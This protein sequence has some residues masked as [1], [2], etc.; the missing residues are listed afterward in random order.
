ME[1]FVGVGTCYLDTILRV[2]YFVE[3]G[4]KAEAA[5]IIR[6]RGGKCPNAIEVLQQLMVAEAA[7]LQVKL[8]AVLP[9]QF[10]P[11]SVDFEVSFAGEDVLRHCIYR[12]D[13][14]EPARRYI[15]RNLQGSSNTIIDHN[16]QGDM[17]LAEFKKAAKKLDTEAAW[18]HFEGR[19]PDVTLKC[20]KHL[21]LKYP[22][23]KISV[24]LD[25][26]ARPGMPDLAPHADVVFFTKSW[27]V[28]KRYSDAQSFL[29]A[30]SFHAKQGS[31]LFCTWGDEDAWA[32]EPFGQGLVHVPAYRVEPH[33]MVVD[34]LDAGDAFVAGIL[35]GLIFHSEDWS[36]EYKLRF[37]NRLAG[38]KI[39]LEGFAGLRELV[40]ED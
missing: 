24:E 35:Y 39:L 7:A 15:I 19:I 33:R 18:Y 23:V 21:R 12:E 6:R 32:Y 27:A 13:E 37:A 10:T 2:D 3:E 31:L 8:V 1:H 14:A 5:S 17:T 26:P 30:Q 20:M 28:D 36:L 29:D 9:N 11:A 16:P 38:N 34:T 4:H 25:E 22:G 40:E